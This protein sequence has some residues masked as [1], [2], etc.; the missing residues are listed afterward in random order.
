[1]TTATNAHHLQKAEFVVSIP[2]FL[3]H[4]STVVIMSSQ[5]TVVAQP[6][7]VHFCVGGWLRGD[8]VFSGG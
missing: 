1:M 3:P 6:V 2:G 4:N 8:V 7:E 5:P